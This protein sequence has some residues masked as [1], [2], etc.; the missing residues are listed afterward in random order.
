[1]SNDEDNSRTSQKKPIK[2]PTSN[3]SKESLTSNLEDKMMVATPSKA[4]Y[5]SYEV[6][7]SSEEESISAKAKDAGQTLKD[8]VISLGQ[9]AKAITEEKTTGL[10]VQAAQ[11]ADLDIKED[12]RDIQNLGDN[13]ESIVTVFENIM[14]DIRKEH[15]GEQERLLVGY[16]K[17]L[18]EQLSVIE[19]RLK[20]AK[21]LKFVS[22]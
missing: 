3:T 11:T 4:E 7:P 5:K 15:Y 20:M 22:E 9:K 8:L 14:T 21:R 13:I 16:K 17:L 10:K 1:V 18:V 12:A 19:A 2:E 6:K